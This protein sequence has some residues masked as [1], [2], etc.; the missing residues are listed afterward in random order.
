M[1][2]SSRRFHGQT[3]WP[4]RTSHRRGGVSLLMHWQLD[5]RTRAGED[6]VF[7]AEY[8]LLR[9]AGHDVSICSLDSGNIMWY[10]L[11][12]IGL[13]TIWSQHGYSQVRDH[14]RRTGAKFAHF[15]NTFPLFS[16]AAY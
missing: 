8:D 9:S 5:Y 2:G 12:S 16:P 3:C 15:H 4:Y 10:E 7:Q 6:V 11:P 13:G 1:R 14:L